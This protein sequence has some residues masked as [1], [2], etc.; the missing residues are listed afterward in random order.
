MLLETD[1]F[2]L[3]FMEE[4]LVNLFMSLHRDSLPEPAMCNYVS[5]TGMYKAQISLLKKTNSPLKLKNLVMLGSF[6]TDILLQKQCYSVSKLLLG[7]KLWR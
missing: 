5:I 1:K 3:G 4:T 2:G 6:H 7:Q